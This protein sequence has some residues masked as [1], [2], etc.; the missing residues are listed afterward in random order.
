MSEGAQ[1]IVS[2]LQ[3]SDEPLFITAWGGTNTL[4]QA[5]Q[6]MDKTMSPAEASTL[7]SRIRLYTISDQDS[8]GAWMR[9]RYPDMFYVVSIHAF[10]EYSAA[11]WPGI[12]VA[13]CACVANE[14]V[15]NPWLD[16]NIRLG[17][18]GSVYPQIEY[19]MEGDTPSFLWLVQNGLVYRDR[20]NWGT[21]GG[22]YSLPQAPS[23]FAEHST[24]KHFVNTIDTAIGADG[25]T[26]ETN[27][28]SI[29]RWRAA[30]Q[31]DFA[32]RM[33]W[34]LTSNFT[35]A[36][37][38]PV[39]NVN[40]H[41]GPD[42]LF[43]EVAANQTYTFNANMTYDP[44]HPDDNS[45]L[46]FLWVL[47]PE[48]T[49][50]LPDYLDIQMKAIDQATG[51]VSAVNDAGFANAVLGTE[52]QITAPSPWTNPETG[53]PTDFHLLLQVTNSAGPYPIRRY[54]RIVCEY[55]DEGNA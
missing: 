37:H 42:P 11:T 18:L 8:T 46:T 33:H 47:Y 34:T 52:L 13:D 36:G 23:D 29:W 16:A 31:D 10:N 26:W 15:L 3:A 1:R 32:A 54:L 4:A 49:M 24:A 17:P 38:P 19:G 35:E 27:Q 9:A 39:L 14:T 20:I 43:V 48:P 51:N 45:N 2:S 5:L 12:N 53:L 7:R 41:Q 6:H 55:G 30:Y 50:F 44:D 25:N 28:A 21:W 22:R 40:G